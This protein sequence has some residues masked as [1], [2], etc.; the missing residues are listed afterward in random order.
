MQVDGQEDE[1]QDESLLRLRG[2]RTVDEEVVQLLGWTFR[3]N[4][5]TLIGIPLPVRDW[6]GQ[7]YHEIQF[8]EETIEVFEITESHPAEIYEWLLERFR[9]RSPAG[10]GKIPHGMPLTFEG[11][12][13]TTE[14][15]GKVE[16]ILFEPEDS[17]AKSIGDQPV[18]VMISYDYGAQGWEW[19]MPSR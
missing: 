19:G 4:Y 15:T 12:T 5:P 3:K 2:Q 8:W 14:R 17:T 11:L 10:S 1:P 16:K 9:A 18:Q 13:V 7:E 6:V